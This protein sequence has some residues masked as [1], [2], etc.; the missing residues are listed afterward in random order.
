MEEQSSENGLL[1][2]LAVYASVITAFLIFMGVMKLHLYY[3]YFGIDIVDY[4]DFTEIIASFLDDIWLIFIFL[5]VMIF[6][7]IVASSGLAYF[8]NLGRK[9]KVSIDTISRGVSMK[10]YKTSSLV[11]LV[12]FFVMFALLEKYVLKIFVYFTVLFFL[13]FL[14]YFAR[15]FSV[16]RKAEKYFDKLIYFVTFFLLV[17]LLARL[18]VL[19]TIKYPKKWSIQTSSFTIS[20]TPGLMYLGKT[21][22]FFFIY[23]KRSGEKWVVPTS[24]LSYMIIQ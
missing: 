6:H 13:Q 14:F 1:K 9:R 18:E 3:G 22:N 4:L 19:R 15:H 8:I 23:D 7:T 16:Y 12:L 11:T 20:N 17:A 2:T 5:A 24:S 21:K 10:A